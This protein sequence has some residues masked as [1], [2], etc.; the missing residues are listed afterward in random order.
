MKFLFTLVFCIVISLQS[1]PQNSFSNKQH[2]LSGT[3]GASLEGGVTHTSSDFRKDGIDIYG[4]VLLEY[5][6]PET[7][8]GAIGLRGYSGAG[9]LSGSGGATG[10]R[11]ELEE[12][13]TQF[14]ILGAGA[15]YLFT[16]SKFFIPYF[17][18]SVLI[19]INSI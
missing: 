5:I 8:V 11:P 12:F 4:R 17:R 14:F 9:Y 13:K 1:F 10:N 16:F 7:R 3:I 15:E 2:P 6:F 19:I 18:A